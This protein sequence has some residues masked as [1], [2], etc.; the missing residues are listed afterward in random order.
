MSSS[1]KT[2]RNPAKGRD[3]CTDQ[4]SVPELLK[5]TYDENPATRRE[6][7]QYLC[8]CHMRRNRPEVWDRILELARDTD[9][10]VRKTVFHILGDGSPPEREQDVIAAMESM[11]Q[12]PDLKLRRC[13]RK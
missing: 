4:E 8:P 1:T 3:M 10:G 13:A 12:D 2:R 6:G 9:L 7:V 11:Y 5:M